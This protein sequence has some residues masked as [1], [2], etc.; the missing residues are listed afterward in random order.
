MTRDLRHARRPRTLRF[1]T[2]ASAAAVALVVSALSG[3]DAAADTSSCAVSTGPTGAYSVKICITAPANEATAAGA[4]AATGTV[5]VTGTSPG[6]A[7]TDWTLDGAHLIIDYQSPHAF[8]LYTTDFVDGS[9]T[10][11][12][13]AILRDGFVSTPATITVTFSNGITQP[14]VNQNQWQAPGIAARP[15][16]QPTVLAVTGDG[17]GGETTAT[18]VVNLMAGWNPDMFLYLGDVYEDGTLTEFRN[19]YGTGGT[20]FDRFRAKTLPIIG[21]HEYDGGQAPGYFNY[22]DNIPHYYSVDVN[23]WHFVAIDSTSQYG[24]T[25]PGDP[26]YEWFKADLEQN[27]SPCTVVFAHHPLYTIGAE[28]PAARLQDMWRL[29]RE[30]R[31]TAFLTGHD[32]NYQRWTP[33]D[34]AGDPDPDGVTEFVVGTG[35]HSSKAVVTSDPRVVAKHKS[36]GALRMDLY[37][38]HANFQYATS[39]GA[40]ID[41]QTLSCKGHDGLAPAAPS[42]LTSTVTGDTSVALGW[43]AAVDNVGVTGYR[44][45]RDGA[46]V[47][48]TTGARAFTDDTAVSATTYTYTVSALDAAGNESALSTGAT[49]RTTGPDVTPPTVPTGGSGTLS[50]PGVVALAWNTS[51]DNVGVDHYAVYRDGAQIGTAT[52]AAYSDATVAPDVGYAYTV[53]AVDAAANRSAPSDPIA[54][55]TGDSEPP[56]VPTGV[57]AT[58]AGPNSVTLS[59]TAST[60]DRAVAAYDVFRDGTPVATVDAPA[61]TYTDPQAL[62]ST[63]YAYT[64]VAVDQAGNRSAPSAAALVTTPAATPIPADADSYVSAANPGTNYG[65]GTSLRSDADPVQRP[66]L[67]FTVSG[68]QAQVTRVRLRIYAT[69]RSTTGFTVRQIDDTSWGERTITWNNAPALGAAVGSVGPFSTG[70]WVEVDVTPLVR[71]DGAVSIAVDTTST[72]ST[73]YGSRESTTQPMLLVD[74]SP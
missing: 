39:S 65:T 69:A 63:T 44:V 40:V 20:F 60:D 56:T 10:L 70:G 68:A 7:K 15:P 74:S 32:H 16:D 9:H 64:V 5:T 27:R 21:N 49:V 3:V 33:M 14:P 24:K 2:T 41:A 67:R 59:W 55:S 62:S 73:A 71:G 51:T 13:A 46:L 58:A 18:A 4:V 36:Y 23:G 28:E 61:T 57:T 30:H 43:D 31:V 47:G 45:Y 26:Q 19:W 29:M 8:T 22:W 52:T 37:G 54:V 35:G 53:E 6:V 34:A 72:T 1:R 48:S 38:D 50:E 42:S 66:Y 17:A 12:A 25:E 11:A